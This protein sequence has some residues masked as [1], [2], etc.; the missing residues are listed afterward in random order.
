M[1][2]ERENGEGETIPASRQPEMHHLQQNKLFNAEKLHKN[3][4]KCCV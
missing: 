1:E 3:T 2:K 4:E